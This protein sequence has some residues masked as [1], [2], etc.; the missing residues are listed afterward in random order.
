[1]SRAVL[2]L[3]GVSKRYKVGPT[4][5]RYDT[6]R[7]ALRRQLASP[8]RRV[9]APELW[10][11]R[12]V[13]ASINAGDVVGIVGRNGAGKST[14]LR[15]VARITE[16]TAGHGRIR[17]RVGSLLDVGTGFHYELT[18]RENIYLG[19]S[20]LGLARAEIRARFD[21]IVDFAEVGRFLDSPLKRY[22]AGMHLRLAFA[23]AAHLPA[24]LL[25]VDEVLAFGDLAFQRKCLSAMSAVGREGRTILFVSHD[26]GA[27]QRL[28]HRALWLEHGRVRAD[29]PTAEILDAY[30]KS[31]GQDVYEAR[32]AEGEGSAVEL[33]AVSVD[34][35]DDGPLEA[36]RRDRPIRIRLRFRTSRAISQLGLGVQLGRG[37]I[38]LLDELITDS[39]DGGL[40]VEADRTYEVSVVVPPILPAG[41]YELSA[42]AA[43]PFETYWERELLSFRLW[44]IPDEPQ[45][46][47]DRRRMSQPPVRWE[48]RDVGAG[49]AGGPGV[50]GAD[51]SS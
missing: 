23:V 5:D 26:L 49:D 50:A 24:E 47:I 10:A 35:D 38:R 27:V 34:H 39:I 36:A 37:G 7:E 8:W 44:P 18:G 12:E 30:S 45:E 40:Q 16:P 13:T 42:W 9:A 22:S 20:V 29:G 1:M 19:G 33:V 48:A 31:F 17:G 51:Q 21:E 15:I 6:F 14:L 46:S 4:S 2:E 3:T 32:F 43:S 25:V 28:C 41:E 11:L